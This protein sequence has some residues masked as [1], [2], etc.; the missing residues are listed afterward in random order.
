MRCLRGHTIS[1]ADY[2]FLP[3]SVVK[4][5]LKRSFMYGH[6]VVNLDAVI[7]NYRYQDDLKNGLLRQSLQEQGVT[8]PAMALWGRI[9]TYT[10]LPTE[11][12]YRHAI[13]P[14]ARARHRLRPARVQRPFLPT[15][16]LLGSDPARAEA[17]G[18]QKMGGEGCQRGHRPS[19]LRDPRLVASHGNAVPFTPWGVRHRVSAWLP[20]TPTCRAPRSALQRL[21]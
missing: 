18:L 3:L 5:S 16:K 17:G 10:A 20:A 7:N 13:D 15:R 1:F 8:Q 14:A 9:A 2:G 21:P 19:G 11:P 12:M 6:R 4:Y